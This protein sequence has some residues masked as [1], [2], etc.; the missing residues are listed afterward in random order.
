[1][2]NVKVITYP[3][4]SKQ[5]RLY[6]SPIVTGADKTENGKER[7][8]REI[9]CDP[10]HGLPVLELED[11]E[12]SASVSRKRSIDK[13]YSYCRCNT[14][15]WF[16]TFTFAPG[17]VDRYNFDD[18]SQKLSKWLNHMRDRYCK[19][20]KYIVVPEMHKD[21]AYHFH[22][23]FS[24]CEGLDIRD[25]GRKV[26]QKYKRG[27]RTCFKAT[28]TPIYIVG[29]YHLGWTTATAVRSNERVTRYIT[30]YVTKDL[31]YAVKGKRRYW[32]SKNLDVPLEEKYMVDPFDKLV[33][34]TELQAESSFVKHIECKDFRQVL[35]VYEIDG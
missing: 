12:R 35:S 4:L 9:D 5:Y 2:Y 30:K 33:M 3:D 26:I 18:C 32:V 25:S 17:K 8:K 31:V 28:D 29:R 11:A 20:L 13:I 7:K 27:N 34:A 21:G 15:D 22:G 1:M 23:L 16:V 10:F 24:D 6:S 14:W 19:G